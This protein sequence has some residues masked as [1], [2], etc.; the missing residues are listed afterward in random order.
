MTN[1]PPDQANIGS[2]LTGYYNLTS[3]GSSVRNTYFSYIVN[4]CFEDIK[5]VPMVEEVAIMMIT[6]NKSNRIRNTV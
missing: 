5:N 6:E 4:L 3:D 1:L 2:V